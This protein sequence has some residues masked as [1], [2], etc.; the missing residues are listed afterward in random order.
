[1]PQKEGRLSAL[2]GTHGYLQGVLGH[3]T[4]LD[5]CFHMVKFKAIW[6]KTC[7]LRTSRESKEE[8][9][10]P[11]RCPCWVFVA[12]GARKCGLPL[13][14]MNW[15]VSWPKLGVL[16]GAVET[17]HVAWDAR[18]GSRL[19]QQAERLFMA[20]GEDLG[21]CRTIGGFS[22]QL[23][24]GASQLQQRIQEPAAVGCY[25]FYLSLKSYRLLSQAARLAGTD[26]LCVLMD[27]GFSKER[28]MKSDGSAN[29]PVVQ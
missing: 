5:F 22:I 4:S 15:T 25:C 19:C 13:Q 7:M 29:M 18:H 17:F 2:A 3:E 11:F 14:C 6:S 20:G 1:M 10:T 23:L 8:R 16:L 12:C 24:F 9:E 26:D 27:R 21:D 28:R